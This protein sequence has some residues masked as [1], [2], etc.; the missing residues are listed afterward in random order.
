MQTARQEAVN[1]STVD[2]HHADVDAQRILDLASGKFY[3]S[4]SRRK[5]S[6]INSAKQTRSKTAATVTDAGLES[7]SGDSGRVLV[8]VTVSFSD[9]AQAQRKPQYGRMRITVQKVGDVAKVTDVVPV[10]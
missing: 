5:Q 9:L 3:D 2:Y 10:S 7:Q 1:L 8:A 6:Y 4:F